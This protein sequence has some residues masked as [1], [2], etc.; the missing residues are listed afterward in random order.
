[1]V[2]WFTDE[3]LVAD[4]APCVSAQENA[5]NPH[6]LATA[7]EHRVIRKDE[8]VLL[9]LWGKLDQPGAVYADITW[10]GFTGPNVPDRM[11]KAFA[12]DLRRARCRGRRSC[13]T[14]RGRDARCA[15]SRPTRPRGRC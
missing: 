11:A 14:R 13:R 10:I 12:R 4:S 2:G 9:D 6:Y 8:L 3:G 7:A 5:G 15:G 1:M